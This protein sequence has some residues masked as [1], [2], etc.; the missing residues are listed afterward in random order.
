MNYQTLQSLIPNHSLFRYE[1]FFDVIPELI[2]LKETIQDKYFHAEGDVWTHTKMVCNSLLDSVEYQQANDENK[3]IL[4]YSALLHDIS[5]PICT[6][7]EGN[8]VTSKGHSKIGAIDTRIL[9][10]KMDVPFDIRE[11]ISNI[12]ANHQVP[13]FAFNNKQGI[14]P[15]FTAHRLSWELP[16]DLLITVATADMKGRDFELKDDCLNDIEL[17]K[18]LAEEENCLHQA[19]IFPDD[20]TRL[21]YFRSQGSIYPDSPFFSELGSNVIVMCG[22][23]AS[24]K[25]T[26]CEYNKDNRP[27]LSFDDMIKKMGLTHTKNVG[28]AIHEVI[29]NAKELLRNKEPFIWNATHLSQQMRNKTLDLLFNYN[30]HISLQYIECPYKDLLSRNQKRDFTLT[31]DKLIKMLY[32]WEVPTPIE[33]HNFNVLINDLDKT[34]GLKV[35]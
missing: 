3:F 29:D 28:K 27:V 5:K 18:L 31:N 25:D 1:D 17:F 22:L 6:K 35:K 13:F 15:N 9:L 26:W 32:K 12:I 7:I 21:A 11:K 14:T 8:R 20:I 10:W 33:T 23:P 4:F 30:A 16:L 19:K 24:G 2:P 34:K